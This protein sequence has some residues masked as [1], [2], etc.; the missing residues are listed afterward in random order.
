MILATQSKVS[1]SDVRAERLQ[2]HSDA[3]KN[4]LRDFFC[5]HNAQVLTK[6]LL[7][8]GPH[9]QL[10]HEKMW[11]SHEE[12]SPGTEHSLRDINLRVQPRTPI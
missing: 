7:S 1:H 10:L 4:S 11:N 12:I 8:A 5:A 6:R 2:T 3:Y 9:H